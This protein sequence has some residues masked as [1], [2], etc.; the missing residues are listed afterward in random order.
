[1]K[2]SN[3]K[4]NDNSW[5]LI[6]LGLE[7]VLIIFMVWVIFS[8]LWTAR[9]EKYRNVSAEQQLYSRTTEETYHTGYLAIATSKEQPREPTFEEIV[10]SYVFN[11]C[12]SYPKVDPYIVL[13]VI[14]QE[15]RFTPNVSSGKC[16]GLM[17]V[18]TYW[19]QDRAARLGV[20]DFW[21]P[22]SNILVGVDLLNELMDMVDGDIYRALTRYNGGSGINNYA[23][24]VINR[25]NEY[26]EGN[27]YG[28][29]SSASQNSARTGGSAYLSSI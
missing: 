21:D 6:L 13:S 11:I 25:A 2:Q 12:Q 23:R 7:L 10:A 4:Q 16:V 17:Q 20:T 9:P 1:M 8:N 27:V 22:Y 15:S 28:P 26:R 19:H 14:Y 29:W 3:R 24:E 18:S 5:K